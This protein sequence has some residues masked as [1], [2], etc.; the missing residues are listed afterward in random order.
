MKKVFYHAKGCERKNNNDCYICKQLIA[1]CWYH[2]K[3]CTSA[4]CR[5][6]YCHHIKNRLQQQQL[7]QRSYCE[8]IPRQDGL[9]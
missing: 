3:S 2:A 7:Q 6:P 8:Q 1:L 5:V 9:P 4:Q